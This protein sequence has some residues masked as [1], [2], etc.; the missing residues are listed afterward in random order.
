M[1]CSGLTWSDS[2]T[3]VLHPDLCHSGKCCFSVQGSETPSAGLSI[4]GP[5]AAIR[6]TASESPEI[7]LFIIIGYV[8]YLLGDFRESCNI[9]TFLACKW[10]HRICPP[11]LPLKQLM[12][13]SKGPL[14][15][16]QAASETLTAWSAR[17]KCFMWIM[18][19]ANS[20]LLVI[21]FNQQL[22]P[23]LGRPG[24]CLSGVNA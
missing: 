13:E 14:I 3:Y 18:V 1:G 22:V 23:R 21:D 6:F 8:A 24:Q 9:S 10:V 17:A 5:Q 20:H 11:Y 16:W 4:M 7:I 19:L 2:L 15:I 12:V